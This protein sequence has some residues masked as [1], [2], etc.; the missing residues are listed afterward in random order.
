MVAVLDASPDSSHVEL[1]STMSGGVSALGSLDTGRMRNELRD[2]NR[3][4]AEPAD[5]KVRAVE[6]L[7]VLRRFVTPQLAGIAEPE[8]VIDVR[9]EFHHAV[10]CATCAEV[11]RGEVEPTCLSRPV[12]TFG[13]TSP[14]RPGE[15]QGTAVKRLDREFAH[16]VGGSTS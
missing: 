15:A 3:R 11:C 16:S 5:Q 10:G 6:R 12:P 2:G 13:I 1:P 4:L 9:C 14:A 7:Y 8:E